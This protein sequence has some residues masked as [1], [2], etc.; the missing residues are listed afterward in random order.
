VEV[1]KR[2]PG[3]WWRSEG[4][5]EVCSGA[6]KEKTRRVVEGKEENQVCGG[7][8]GENEQCG[9]GEG[10]NEECGGGGK[11][12]NRRVE[13]VGRRKRGC[14]GGGKEKTRRV[15][16]VG[17]RKPGVWWRG[18]GEHEECGAGGKAN[19][20]RVVEGGRSEPGAQQYLHSSSYL[21]CAKMQQG[22]RGCCFIFRPYSPPTANSHSYGQNTQIFVCVC[23]AAD[24]AR[25]LRIF[26]HTH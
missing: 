5:H 10:E 11:D 4:E 2:K 9:G 20:R 14:G 26:S 17:R 19:T 12:K 13:E 7:G 25:M 3:V 24:T 15:V 6:G 8:V 22:P 21:R 18:K 23:R 16:E 1:G